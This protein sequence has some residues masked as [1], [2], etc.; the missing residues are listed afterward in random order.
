MRLTLVLFVGLLPLLEARLKCGWII[1]G[2]V[3]LLDNGQCPFDALCPPG[4]HRKELAGK[5][6]CVAKT[7]KS[8]KNA[9]SF[10]S[11]QWILQ[12][13]L[14]VY[15][16]NF[17]EA[18]GKMFKETLQSIDAILLEAKKD[19]KADTS[20]TNVEMKIDEA[21]KAISNSMIGGVHRL[22]G[23]IDVEFNKVLAFVFEPS[24]SD[25]SAK[26]RLVSKE[27]EAIYNRGEAAFNFFQQTLDKMNWWGEVIQNKCQT[28]G[29]NP[30]KIFWSRSCGL[31]LLGV[32]EFQHF[33][34]L[35]RCLPSPWPMLASCERLPLVSELVVLVAS[36][37]CGERADSPCNIWC[38][39]SVSVASREDF[40][41][42]SATY[43]LF[44]FVT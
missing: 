3:S 5:C 40:R 15:P 9:E 29:T 8:K 13:F 22:A 1:P 10:I 17:D 27:V 43:F 7:P 25:L 18:K 12:N 44:Y 32:V 35:L 14:K 34:R 39:S 4:L 28:C 41:S 11:F 33:P 16:Q 38:S 19:L 30:E 2:C 6:C 20:R 26:M 24:E 36:D 37:R 21:S 23:L 31:V 42:G